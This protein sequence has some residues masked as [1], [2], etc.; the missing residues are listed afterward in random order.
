MADVSRRASGRPSR[1]GCANITFVATGVEH[2]PSAFDGLADRV[3]VHFPW[4]SLLRGALGLDISVASAIA[5]L[6]A[7]DGHV[8]IVLSI[9]DRDRVVVGRDTFGPADV[10]RIATVYADLGLDLTEAR[11]LTPDEVRATGSTWARRL[12]AGDRPVWCVGLR[13]PPPDVVD[14]G[15]PIPTLVGYPRSER[16]QGG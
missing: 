10:A 3:I 16:M 11:R 9:V 12:R 2:V 15:P 4:G 6:V 7:P 13:R 5:R 14:A 1:R 8:D